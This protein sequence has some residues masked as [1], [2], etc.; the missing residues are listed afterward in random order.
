MGK[1]IPS[2]EPVLEDEI[3]ESPETAPLT[4]ER[5]AD[6]PTKDETPEESVRAALKEIEKEQNKGDQG[7]ETA[8]EAEKP[9]TD[10]VSPD[11]ALDKPEVEAESQDFESPSRLTASERELFNKLPKKFKPAVTRMFRDH[12]AQFIKTQTE[13][14]KH[15][16]EAKHVVE[17]VRPYYVSH[18][19]L[20]ANGVTEGHLVAALIGA[21]QKLTDP[22]TDKQTLIALAADRGYRIQFVDETGEILSQNGANGNIHQNISNDPNFLALQE[23]HNRLLSEIEQQRSQAAAAPIV[24]QWE[25]IKNEKDALGNFRYPKLLEEQTWEDMKPLVF[26]LSKTGRSPSEILKSAY[27]ALYGQPLGQLNQT[28]LIASN[29]PQNRAV[30]A[31][32]SVRARTAPIMTASLSDKDVPK[33]ETAEQ[34]AWAAYEQLRRGST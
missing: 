9:L 26:A 1:E 3:S 21:H 8:P 25:A 27:I 14:N 31:G 12:N 4:G 6:E 16:N 32:S 2:T 17:A 33:N 7:E 30:T 24:A 19:E 20:A 10:V 23:S 11:K 34:S 28:G 5:E 29:N 15:V 18:P 22:K 13:L